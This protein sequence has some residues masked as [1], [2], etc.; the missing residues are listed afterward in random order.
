MAIPVWSPKRRI[1]STSVRWCRRAASKARSTTGTSSS[2]TIG[3]EGGTDL[4]AAFFGTATAPLNFCGVAGYEDLQGR[5]TF[6]GGCSPA[7][8]IR[9]RV[10]VINGPQEDVSGMDGSL[11]YLFEG[12]SAAELL[13][14]VDASY[15]LKYER[16]ALI[17]AGSL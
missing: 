7:N 11:S 5:F 1:L 15:T 16:E 8:L 6:V 4:A 12:W 9:T 2:K 17:V 3:T 10:N 13:V 14:G